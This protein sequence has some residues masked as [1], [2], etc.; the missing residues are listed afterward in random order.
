MEN[1]IN[2]MT[3]I[4]HKVVD[5][6][7]K[8]PIFERLEGN[9]WY[10]VEDALTDFLSNDFGIRWQIFKEM[11]RANHTEDV[12]N[13]LAERRLI[14]TFEELDNLLENYED[15]LSNDDSWHTA[16]GLAI[17]DFQNKRG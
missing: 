11:E 2:G 5:F 10:E 12:K 1:L 17:D 6:M 14:V 15:N 8:T 16:L 3:P 9:K 4:R 13:E 7:N